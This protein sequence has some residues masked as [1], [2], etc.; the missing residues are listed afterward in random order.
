MTFAIAAAAACGGGSH[1][2]TTPLAS[3][4]TTYTNN[5]NVT[6]QQVTPAPAAKDCPLD[7]ASADV[8]TE[9]IEGGI[10]LV[11]V[12]DDEHVGAVRARVHDFAG[13][14]AAAADPATAPLV[15]GMHG[16]RIGTV[17]VTA[18]VTDTADGA[19][20]ELRPLDPAQLGEL[21]RQ[22]RS[23]VVAMESGACRTGEHDRG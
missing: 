17:A 19:R 14:P 20:L 13:T 16:A 5:P 23:N 11:F 21:R 9:P 8:M 6:E 2:D 3:Q 7:V 10:A 22:A 4:Q 12:A 18:T 1:R 15:D